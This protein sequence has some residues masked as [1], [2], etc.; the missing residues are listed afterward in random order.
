MIRFRLPE[1]GTLRQNSEVDPLRYYYKPLVGR[2]FCARIQIGLDLLPGRF[3]RLL[4]IGYGSGLLMPTLS[5]CADEL[6][7]ADREPEPPGLLEALSRLG[8]RIK[9]LMQADLARGL[10]FQ[11][12]F[13][14]GVVAFSILE[15]LRAEELT[16]AF[17]EL[18]RVLAPGGRLLVGCP[19]V[20]PLMNLAFR[21]I[22][23]SGIE[24][25][26]FSSMADV[27]ASSKPCFRVDGIATLPRMLRRLPVGL[28]P[29]TAAL[30]VKE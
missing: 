6:Y 12:G 11:D 1:Q 22:G 17:A 14:D 10:P 4:E 5:A 13:F 26:H 27:L 7:G 3:R 20:H 25:H 18:G 16:R 8:V 9:G 30:L 24:H 19:A 29:Y 2:V 15:H 23:F 28:A 21:A